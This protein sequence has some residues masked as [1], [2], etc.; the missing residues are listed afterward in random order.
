MVKIKLL[1]F[2]FIII[3][4]LQSC[5]KDDEKDANKPPETYFSL[6]EIN[7]SG[8]NRLNSI[9][10]LT[11]YGKDQDGYVKEYELSLDGE[12]WTTTTTQDSTFRFSISAGSDTTDIL[13][14]VRAVDNEGLR[15]PTPDQLKIP[16]K[17]TP[18]VV[19]FD[20]DLVIPDTANLVATTEWDAT[21]VDGDETITQVFI[22]L[23]GLNWYELNKSKK[24]ISIVPVDG[25]ATDTTA[26]YIYYG[27][28]K[29]PATETIPGLSMNDTNKLFIKAV[30]QAGTESLVD[31]SNTFFMKGKQH[32]I[33]VV[34]GVSVANSTYKNIFNAI[35]VDYDFLDFAFNNGSLQP[36][37]WNITFRLQ[38]SFY[39]KLFFYSDE[40]LY[41]NPYSNV[42]SLILEFAASSLQE[43]AN[44]GGKYF[45]STSFD[46]NTPL[47]G[48]AGVLPIESVSSLNYGSARLYQDSSVVSASN[49]F[50]DLKTSAFA[51]VGVGVFNIDSADTEVLY[52]AELSDNKRNP[53]GEWMDTKIVASGRR[54]NGNLNQVFFSIQLWEMNGDPMALQSLFNQIL[55][56]EFN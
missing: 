1:F 34:G 26:A 54:V 39:S 17:N 53:I 20:D 46:H 21:D 51:I 7:L 5:R 44:S 35:N 15:D 43:Y 45:I 29:N 30:D 16:I 49:N 24:I 52:E 18:P 41:I 32:D 6:E 28:D 40:T 9:V 50:P 11:W 38:L 37:I 22:S 2:F 36:Q 55:T 14:S 12:N 48:F 3:F 23:N 31:T 42:K 19:S 8:E 10:R 27:T 47:D 33:L 4:S 13:I 56:V 25:N